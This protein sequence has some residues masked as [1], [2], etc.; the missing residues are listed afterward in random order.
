[1]GTD[2]VEQIP[3]LRIRKIPPKTEDKEAKSDQN[4]NSDQ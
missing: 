3:E 1:M 4:A 2:V